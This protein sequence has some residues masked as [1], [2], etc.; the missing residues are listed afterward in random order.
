M[1]VA[2]DNRQTVTLEWFLEIA[3]RSKK[4]MRYFF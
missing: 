4:D 2:S 3:M 1:K